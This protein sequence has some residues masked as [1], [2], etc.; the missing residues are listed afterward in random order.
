V[1]LKFILAHQEARRRAMAAIVE[2]PTG[3]AVTIKPPT[4]N[5][6]QNARL[7][8][9]LDEIA[10]QVEW[11]GKKRDSETW[12]RLL[13]ASWLRARGEQVE[14][15]PALDGRGVDIIFRKTSTTTKEEMSELIEYVCAWKADQITCSG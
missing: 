15:L 13:T 6:D 2:A 10:E 8:A 4:R 1:K 12:K 5:L 14:F 7:H 3:Y 9:E 11:A